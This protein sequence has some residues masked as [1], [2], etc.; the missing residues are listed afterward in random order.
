MRTHRSRTKGLPVKTS[1]CDREPDILEAVLSGH[2][3]H[4]VRAH[5]RACPICSD[6]ALAADL[7][8]SEQA[9]AVHEA[10][11][12]TAGQVWWRATMRRRAEA[13]ATAARPITLIQGVAGASAA[14]A[15]AAF[16]TVAWSSVEQPLGRIVAAI[17]RDR[18]PTDA[19][20]WPAAA[21]LPAI[22]SLA[23]IVA[24][25]LILTPLVFYFALSDE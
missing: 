18:L 17:G 16:V 5:A 11:V 8:R 3:P 25:G 4:D 14:G 22:V 23:L 6:V 9:E 19:L 21:T 24:A 1:D 7:L 12:P 10:P 15:C 20:A 13:S 2:W